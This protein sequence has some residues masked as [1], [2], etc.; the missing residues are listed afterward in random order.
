MNLNEQ[1]TQPQDLSYIQIPLTQGQ[2]AIVSPEVFD[3]AKWK[4]C[5]AWDP[6]MQSYC[7]RRK[8]TTVNGKQTTILMHRVIM[9]MVFGRPLAKG[10]QVDHINHDTLDNRRENLRL[11]THAENCRNRGVYKNNKL[12]VKGVFWY[13]R[14]GVWRAQVM[15]DGKSYQKCFPPDQLSEAAAWV[16]AKREKLH[17]EFACQ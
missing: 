17:G 16:A 13:K 8:S 6:S 14:D 11:A 5:A 1:A 7:A 4:W 12:G 2:I 10:E 3:L 9:E 15:A